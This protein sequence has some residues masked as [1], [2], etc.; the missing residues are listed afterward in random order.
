MTVAENKEKIRFWFEETLRGG[1]SAERLREVGE[2]IISPD[3]V[4]HD[5]PDPEH[6]WDAMIRAVPGLLRVL[7]DCRFTVEQI[8][9]EGDLVAVRVRG[10]ATHTGEGMG[11]AP[12]GKHISWTENEIFRFADGRVVESWGE[13]GLDEALAVIGL[14]FRSGKG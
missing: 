14:G 9:G 4:D 7:P 10:E 11:I 2:R 5:G 1:V 6:G 3:F 8:I 12:T 13:G